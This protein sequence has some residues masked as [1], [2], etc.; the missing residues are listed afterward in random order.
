[1]STPKHG[2]VVHTE[3]GSR[4]EATVERDSPWYS[5]NENWVVKDGDSGKVVSRHGSRSDA[6]NAAKKYVGNS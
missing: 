6:V 2:Q 5:L 3:T 1:M 4:R